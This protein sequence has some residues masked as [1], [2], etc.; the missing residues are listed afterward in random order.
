LQ[1]LLHV[2]DNDWPLARAVQAPRLHVE[3][4]HLWFEVTGLA[5]GAEAVLRR[6]WTES[7]RFD[8]HSMFFGGVHAVGYDGDALVG[9]G[10]ARRGGTVAIVRQSSSTNS[11]NRA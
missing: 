5:E 3:G 4:D 10:D 7:T 6:R 1:V 11:K 2:I 9:A 8:H